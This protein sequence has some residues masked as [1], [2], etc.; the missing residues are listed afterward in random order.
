MQL[1]GVRPSV[2]LSV[3]SGRCRTPLLQVCCCAPD[4]H[5]P[6]DIDRLL[7]GRRAGG[8]Q[9]QQMRGVPRCQLT[10]EAEHK[11][12]FRLFRP[13]VC[14][15]TRVRGEGTEAF[16]R[17]ACHTSSS[18]LSCITRRSFD[19]AAFSFS[20]LQIHYEYSEVAATVSERI[21]NVMKNLIKYRDANDTEILRRV[22]PIFG[23]SP[24]MPLVQCLK[25]TEEG[26]CSV[27]SVSTTERMALFLISTSEDLWG[28]YS[29]SARTTRLSY[30]PFAS[31]PSANYRCTSVRKNAFRG[32]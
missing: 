9:Q 6:R 17:R 30:H 1:S 29:P 4:G 15:C 19:C 7:H 13:F 18:R 21:G 2:C 20:L 23:P 10:Q 28:H 31:D 26:P 32:Y 12:R 8:R 5:L 14:L 3:Q 27:L 11:I 22:L 24:K 16:P 25:A